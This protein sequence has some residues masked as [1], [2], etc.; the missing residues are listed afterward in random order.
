MVAFDA[1]ESPR[2]IQLY[3]VDPRHRR[4][5]GAHGRRRGPAPTTS[6]STSAARCPRSPARGA[7]ARCPGSADLFRAD[8]PCGR[9]SRR[10]PGARH[11]ED[12]QGH[13]RRPRSRTSTRGSRRRRRAPPGW[14]CTPAPRRSC[15]AGR[16][17]E[18]RS[19]GW[20]SCWGRSARRCWETATSGPPRTRSTWWPRRAARAWSSG[21]G[22]WGGPGCSASSPLPSRGSPSPAS[23]TSPSVAAIDAA[24]REPAGR[25]V[26]RRRG[27]GVRDFRKHV[28]WYT[29]GFAVGGDTRR[30]LAMVGDPGRARRP[31]R[32][33]RPP[34]SR[35]PPKWRQGRAAA[36][37]A[38]AARPC[39]T[40]GWTR[41]SSPR[42]P[43][44]RRPSSASAAAE[45]QP[46]GPVPAPTSLTGT[47]AGPPRRC[48]GGPCP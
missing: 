3:G 43:T 18:A 23:P 24:A 1:D 42:A 29:K 41:A 8:R 9:A 37:A 39:R 48:S 44:C 12:A 40:A 11:G 26:V 38:S 31:A 10:R 33:D 13:R 5:R 25:G 32:D 35:T 30:A 46:R 28:A 4:R 15:T 20:S 21:A 27:K 2:S 14:R 47:A 16:P 22:A 17:T 36:P 7:G 6:T 34:T 19:R 45:R